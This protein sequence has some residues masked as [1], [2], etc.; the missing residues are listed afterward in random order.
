MSDQ[1]LLKISKMPVEVQQLALGG[2]LSRLFDSDNVLLTVVGGAAVQYYT[3]AEYTTKDLDAILV[4]DTT[5]IIERVMGSIGFK[6]TSTYRH[7]EHP[8][9][10]FVVEFP[11]SPIEVGNRHIGDVNIVEFEGYRVRVIR[12]EDIIMDRIIAGVEWGQKSRLEQAR[13]L[14]LKNQKF[15]DLKYLK[16]FAKSEGYE[17]DLKQIMKPLKP[18]KKPKK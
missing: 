10:P 9:F 18:V 3:K 6:R 2:Y 17:K 16:H 5:T 7:F 1:E 11:P 4:G 12:I 13:L 14:W 8:L 15:I